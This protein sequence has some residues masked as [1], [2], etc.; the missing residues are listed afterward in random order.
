MV[1]VRDVRRRFGDHEVLRGASL[2][3]AEGEM[4]ALLGRSGS[5]KSTLLH[6]MAGLD[7][8]YTGQVCLAGQDLATLDDRA[9]SRLRNETVG[10][11][12][13]A[14][15]LLDHLSCAENVMLPYAFSAAP[16]PPAAARRLAMEALSR[17]GLAD[18]AHSLPGALSGG[19]RQR[20]AIA[21]A[22]CLQPRLLLCD[23]PTGNLDEE[24]GEQILEL[25]SAL[26]R[27]GLSLLLV[28]HEQ[29]TSRRADRVLWLREGVLHAEAGP[30]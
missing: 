4:V 8:D 5:G 3:V 7:R 22:L 1:Q 13:Q 6:L 20:V 15:H 21:R 14:F 29:R 19:Q 16:R 26:H 23:E 18:R 30:A 9:L 17:V 12:F 25:F 10:I 2:T 27:E 28:T 11:V 24:T